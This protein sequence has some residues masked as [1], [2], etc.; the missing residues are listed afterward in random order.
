MAI[1]IKVIAFFFFFE[2]KY[3]S[4]KVDLNGVEALV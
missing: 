1:T 3:K 4:E 2:I